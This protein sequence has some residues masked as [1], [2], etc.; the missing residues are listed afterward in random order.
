MRLRTLAPLMALLVAFP[1]AAQRHT[2]TSTHVVQDDGDHRL[3][4]RMSGDVVFNEEGDWVVAV[5]LGGSLR[6]EE[7]DDDDERRIEFRRGDV[8]GVSVRLWD[9]GRETALDAASRAWARRVILSAVRESGLGA[10]GRV[11]RIRARRGVAGVLEEIGRIRGD[12]GRRLYFQALLDGAPMSGA[13]FARVMD[14][15]G[16]LMHSDTETRLVLIAASD[17]APD[18]PR[19][20]ALLRAVR[21]ID[22]DTEVRLVLAHVIDGRRLR[23]PAAADAYFRAVASL[24]SDVERRLVLSQLGDEGL[25]PAMEARFFE[26]AS[27]MGSDTERRLVLT[28]VLDSS[29][30]EARVLGALR[31]TQGM[32]SDTE[33]R[34][35]LSTVPSA[36][37]RSRAVASAYQAVL[38]TMSSDAERTLALRRLAAAQ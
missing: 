28:G 23:D 20:A 24:E 33:K 2:S 11:E 31:A 12:T 3:E 30:S 13:E 4:V 18:G 8:G 34:L 17:A 35:V 14:D 29:A 7:A 1:A 27:A 38:R 19:L 5:P 6:I 9:R 21:G 15:V 32:S 10:R 22:S 16:R 25:D 37:L 36:R 26:A